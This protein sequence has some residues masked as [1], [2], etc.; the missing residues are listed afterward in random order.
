VLI[1]ETAL[2]RCRMSDRKNHKWT[3]SDELLHLLGFSSFLVVEAQ[4]VVI[5]GIRRVRAKSERGEQAV[6]RINLNEAEDSK[7]P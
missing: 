4:S 3:V 6:G 7:K 2:I 1:R 5:D